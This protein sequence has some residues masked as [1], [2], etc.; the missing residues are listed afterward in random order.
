M[1]SVHKH[2]ADPRTPYHPYG[3]GK[4]YPL[5]PNGGK[6]MM[7]GTS[8]PVGT[9]IRGGKGTA[10]GKGLSGGRPTTSIGHYAP[11]TACATAVNGSAFNSI[12][13]FP[14]DATVIPAP[15]GFIMEP[16]PR[17][18]REAPS[19]IE[20]RARR[21][22]DNMTRFTPVTEQVAVQLA[23]V[24]AMMQQTKACVTKATYSARQVCDAFTGLAA[25]GVPIGQAE[26]V[27][28][29]FPNVLPAT[30]SDDAEEDEPAE[31]SEEEGQVPPPPKFTIP[32]KPAYPA[33]PQEEFEFIT[34]FEPFD[35][36][37]DD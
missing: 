10:G 6:G 35:A 25:M 33:L 5:A 36:N 2:P 11:A 19:D 9:S 21:V 17:K 28:P 1:S 37:G 18:N 23:H 30:D 12:R 20:A 31:F 29:G 3:R 24:F 7:H 22:H 4:G 13:A 8:T 16:A 14:P 34:S 15:D 32:K 27:S 26:P